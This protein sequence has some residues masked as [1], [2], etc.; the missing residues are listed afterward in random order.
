MFSFAIWLDYLALDLVDSDL[1]RQLCVD[2]GC[3]GGL[4]IKAVANLP[5]GPA[6]AIHCK[7]NEVIC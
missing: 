2:L 1:A 4:A 7:F 3:L 6:F 5:H